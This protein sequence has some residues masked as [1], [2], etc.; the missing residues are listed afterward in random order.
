VDKLP[1]LIEALSALKAVDAQ[2]FERLSSDLARHSGK[3]VCVGVGK[4]GHIA[5]KVASSFTSIGL[6]ALFLHPTEAAHGDLGLLEKGDY[7]LAFSNSGHTHELKPVIKRAQEI[8]AFVVAIT[9]G[10]SSLLAKTAQYVLAFP[11]VQEICP[12]GLAPTTSTLLMLALGDLLMVSVAE[13]RNLKM[14]TYK[15]LHPAGHLGFK[16]QQAQDIMRHGQAMPVV[17]PKTLM[18]EGLLVMTEKKLG[19]LLVVDGNQKLLGLITDGDLRRAMSP[20]LTLKRAGDIMSES[21]IVC[22]PEESVERVVDL[23]KTHQ[24]GCVGVVDVKG[25]LKGLVHWQDCVHFEKE[26]KGF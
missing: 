9:S 20:D 11:K 4:S 6:P 25:Y 2:V 5:Q 18:S 14:K 12:L 1:R 13:R 17:L 10:A 26:S 22:G 24:V 3:V 21:P 15:A 19:V 7:V 16:M 23:L 8:K